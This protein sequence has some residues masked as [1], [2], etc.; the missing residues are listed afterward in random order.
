MISANQRTQGNKGR[1]GISLDLSPRGVYLIQWP[2]GDVPANRVSFSTESSRTGLYFIGQDRVTPF[3]SIFRDR[4]ILFASSLS[5]NIQISYPR[6]LGA[7]KR[8]KN[9]DSYQKI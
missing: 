8:F 5:Q 6:A 2:A 3:A 1:K 9:E 4:V 7:P